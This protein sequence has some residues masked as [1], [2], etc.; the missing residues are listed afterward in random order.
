MLQECNVLCNVQDLG[1]LVQIYKDYKVYTVKIHI[2]TTEIQ[3]YTHL[4]STDL[5]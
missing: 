4:S 2:K 5:A 3:S 1:I